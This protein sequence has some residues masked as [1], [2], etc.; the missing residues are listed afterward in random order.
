MSTPAYTVQ[1]RVRIPL[2]PPEQNI[3]RERFFATA[4]ERVPNGTRVR[5]ENTGAM[6]REYAVSVTAGLQPSRRKSVRVVVESLSLRHD[7]MPAN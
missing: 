4:E 7:T 6:L 5:D 1:E 3:P 2:S